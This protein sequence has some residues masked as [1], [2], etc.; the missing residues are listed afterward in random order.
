MGSYYSQYVQRSGEGL[1]GRAKH[2]RA[3]SGK[4]MKVIKSKTSKLLRVV[5]TCEGKLTTQSSLLVIGFKNNKT[6]AP[7]KSF[8][9]LLQSTLSQIFQTRMIFIHISIIILRDARV[10]SYLSLYQNQ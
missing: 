2:P 6:S 8:C 10:S 3:N 5:V 4:T 1:P 7:A 9:A